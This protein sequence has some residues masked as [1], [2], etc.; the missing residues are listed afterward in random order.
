MADRRSRIW[1]AELTVVGLQF[2]WK[3]SGREMLAQNVPIPVALEREPDNPADPNAVKVV[4]MGDYKLTRLRGVHLGYLRR[5]IAE[6]LA[7]KL[8]AGTI[9][10]VKLW[11]TEVEPDSGD[12]TLQARFRDIPSGRKKARK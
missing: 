8:D 1:T 4:I 7:P 3:K 9:E 12:A 2:R 10:S 11:V 5:N 6:L